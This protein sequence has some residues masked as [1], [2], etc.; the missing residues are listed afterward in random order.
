MPSD[1]VKELKAMKKL[2]TLLCLKMGAA[3]EEIDMATD[4]G[5]GNVSTMFPGVKR[6]K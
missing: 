2:L 4:K 5:A 3:S 1:E 6:S